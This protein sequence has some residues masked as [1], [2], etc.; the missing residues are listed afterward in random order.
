MRNELPN[1]LYV[2]IRPA[3]EADGNDDSQIAALLFGILI[4]AAVMAF[5][6]GFGAWIFA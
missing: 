6:V 1:P 3:P 5:G 2:S 4:G